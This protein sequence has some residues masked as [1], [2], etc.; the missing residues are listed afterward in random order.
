MHSSRVDF[1]SLQT[2]QGLGLLVVGETDG[3]G[4]EARL[5]VLDGKAVV[6]LVCGWRWIDPGLT[7]YGCR[8]GRRG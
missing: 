2:Q 7:F 6:V 5:L 8:G 1:S 3:W 4:V